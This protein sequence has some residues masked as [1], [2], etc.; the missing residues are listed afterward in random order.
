MH[1]SIA[2]A[3]RLSHTKAALASI[4]V[5]QVGFQVNRAGHVRGS[6]NFRS[7]KLSFLPSL[8]PWPLPSRSLVSARSES[9]S[10]LHLSQSCTSSV[11]PFFTTS[12]SHLA[13]RSAE[14]CPQ[15]NA[16]RSRNFP[17]LPARRYLRHGHGF[18]F[19]RLRRTLLRRSCDGNLLWCR[20]H[21]HSSVF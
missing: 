2:L 7:P 12:H 5:S 11:P 13:P 20:L 19:S 14:T 3:P 16:C 9:H 21:G 18:R 15:R 6:S 1:R 8:S 10:S 17:P 4:Y